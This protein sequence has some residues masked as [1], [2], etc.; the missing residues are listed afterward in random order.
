[1]RGRNFQHLLYLFRPETAAAQAPDALD[2]MLADARRIDGWFRRSSG[3]ELDLG[4][5]VTMGLV[6]MSA[7][8]I[9]C[10][11]VLA[12]AVTLSWYAAQQLQAR[13]ARRQGVSVSVG[14]STAR[15]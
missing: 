6:G 4:T 11:Q 1:M 2:R 10:G 14:G 12:P 3:G 7:Y 8:Q 15:A 9:V 5:L 13:A